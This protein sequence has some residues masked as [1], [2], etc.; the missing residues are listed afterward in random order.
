MLSREPYTHLVSRHPGVVL[1]EVG[2]GP[3]PRRIAVRAGVRGLLGAPV[4]HLRLLLLLLVVA[5]V[6]G[7]VHE[8]PLDD[9]VVGAA[10]VLARVGDP[11]A[12]ARP[13]YGAR[14]VLV[15]LV[16]VRLLVRL[17]LHVRLDVV[18]IWVAERLLLLLKVVV[19]LLRRRRGGPG[20]VGGCCRVGEVSSAAALGVERPIV[21]HGLALRQRG[22][23][24]RGGA[25]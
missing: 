1:V 21:R 12:A 18:G 23:R 2:L 5:T 19:V 22:R 13:H 6:P 9:L 4:H 8:V 25:P 20:K 11:H 17:L 16:R 15:H 24:R 3:S 14:Q 10:R 7:A